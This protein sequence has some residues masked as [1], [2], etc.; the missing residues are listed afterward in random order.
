MC[1]HLRRCQDIDNAQVELPLIHDLLTRRV[2][3]HRDPRG[4]LVAIHRLVDVFFYESHN[5]A[6]TMRAY[7]G[8]SGR[9]YSL[10]ESYALFT[11]LRRLGVLAHS[12]I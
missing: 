7:W 3:A 10:N 9:G 1:R 11:R 4:G 2:R 6:K 8:D 12:W 5:D